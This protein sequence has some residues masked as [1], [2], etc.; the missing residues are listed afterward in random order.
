MFTVSLYLQGY[1]SHLSSATPSPPQAAVRRRFRLYPPGGSVG[2]EG[3]GII[4][5][6]P[7]PYAEMTSRHFRNDSM[8]GMNVS[9]KTSSLKSR[10]LTP[11]KIMTDL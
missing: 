4:I 10:F 11:A 2:V 7:P 6:L 8:L 9:V 3:A 5:M 1:L